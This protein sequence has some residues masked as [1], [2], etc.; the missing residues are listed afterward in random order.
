VSDA[1]GQQPAGDKEGVVPWTDNDDAV[2][3]RAVRAGSTDDQR[4]TVLECHG[5]PTRLAIG[6]LAGGRPRAD[7]LR[8]L[9][10]QHEPRRAEDR[11]CH[12][13]RDTLLAE[14]HNSSPANPGS[15]AV[16]RPGA[17]RVKRRF[18][19]RSGRARHVPERVGS[20][21]F[22]EFS[23]IA[24]LWSGRC[25]WSHVGTPVGGVIVVVCTTSCSAGGQTST[26]DFTR[27]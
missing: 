1:R 27:R 3:G 5:R 20:R 6:R 24:P 19:L 17:T 11:G 4:A 10:A 9:R 15:A 22:H 8:R 14:S 21:E 23:H 25:G 18:G 13:R 26:P 16:R 7:G 2:G 12:E